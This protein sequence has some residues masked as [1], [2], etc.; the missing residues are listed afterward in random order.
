MIDQLTQAI[1]SH[2]WPIVVGCVLTILVQLGRGPLSAQWQRL[3]AVWRPIVPAVLGLLATAGESLASGRT[4]LYAV[5][6]AL[7]AGL[8]PL[9]LALP[10][11]VVPDA[12]P[13]TT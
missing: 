12:K 6:S 4:W 7:V 1:Q 8:P 10:S 3:P 9:L 13:P 2:A 5:V 11:P